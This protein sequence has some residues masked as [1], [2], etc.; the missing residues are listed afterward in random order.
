M[1]WLRKIWNKLRGAPDACFIACDFSDECLRE[2]G[3]YVVQGMSEFFDLLLPCNEEE[4]NLLAAFL[5]AP[6]V[7]LFQ[8]WCAICLGR[9]KT[10]L[11]LPILSM[12]VEQPE[13]LEQF[14][15]SQKW[16]LGWEMTR[17]EMT[18]TYAL[19][20]NS[21][22]QRIML[23][24]WV[25]G[26][27]DKV[28]GLVTITLG[29]VPL[30]P[31]NPREPLNIATRQAATEGNTIIVAA[32][33]SGGFVDGNS[34]NPWS[35]AP[36]VV[37][38]GATNEDGTELLKTSSRGVEGLAYEAPTIV[39]PGESSSRFSA[40]E[41][42]HLVAIENIKNA[43]PGAIETTVVGSH[44]YT[45]TKEKDGRIYVS[46]SQEGVVS[47]QAPL[48]DV[49][50]WMES[51]KMSTETVDISGT[52][53]AAEY[54]SAICREIVTRVRAL[55]TELPKPLRPKLA[56]TMLEDM[57]K[58][59]GNYRPWEIGK[60][61]VTLPIAKEYLSSLTSAHLDQLCNR[62]SSRW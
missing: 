30:H 48:E 33:N 53:F 39:A 52:S 54:V 41:H 49:Q 60:G 57:A 38:V 34:L 45:Y 24:T 51:Q 21:V 22:R 19:L 47:T 3:R 14:L 15:R 61:L 18:D 2:H 26:C 1:T 46:M 8:S 17:A 11:P 23:P 28:W 25:P 36:W 56:K 9:R 59:F 43:L 20:L 4:T 50:K 12:E 40:L 32:G 58:P 55:R 44:L 13:P 16:V 29:P 10:Y 42:G 62:A 37:G 7:S 27:D 6:H 35:V 5:T 31:Y